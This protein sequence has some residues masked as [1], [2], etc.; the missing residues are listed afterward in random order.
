MF[1]IVTTY[2][3]QHLTGGYITSLEITRNKCAIIATRLLSERKAAAC[4]I[5]VGN[6]ISN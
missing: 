2:I 3:I 1:T 4:P 6:T 5:K